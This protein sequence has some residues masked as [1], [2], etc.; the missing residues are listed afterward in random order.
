VILSVDTDIYLHA[1]PTEDP[2]KAESGGPDVMF[3]T[4]FPAPGTYKLWA[5]FKHN[6]KIITAPFVV[7]V[8]GTA[9]AP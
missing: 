9:P 5:E 2:A 8:G 6:D 1:H 7:K 4:R 3:R